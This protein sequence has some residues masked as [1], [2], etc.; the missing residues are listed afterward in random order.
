MEELEMSTQSSF[1]RNAAL[2]TTLALIVGFGAMAKVLNAREPDV[3]NARE[4]VPGAVHQAAA[5]G[6]VPGSTASASN[7]SA[8][9]PAAFS[10]SPTE[11][12][13]QLA[14]VFVDLAQKVTPAVVQ[15]E[16]RRPE[17]GSGESIQD[18]P[19]PFRQFFDL[20][21]GGRSQPMPE[22]MAGGTGF[23][24]SPEGY[25]LT[26][27]H[28]VD[29]ADR[30]VVNLVDRTSHAA[31][32]VGEDLTTDLAV[33]KVDAG[34]LPTLPMGSSHDLKVG[35]PVMAVGNP[36]FSGS[37]ALDYTVT[38]GIVSAVGRPLS[39][40]RQSLQ[41]DPDLAGYAIENFI[42]TDAVINPGNSGGPLVNLQGEVVGINS[43]IASTNGHYQGYGFAIPVD[44]AKKI[45]S[46]LMEH[47]RVRRGWLGISVTG[48]SSEDAEAYHLPRVGGVL[49]Q[50]VTSD[51]PA[52]K[53][54]LQAEDVIMAVNG[55][56]VE[57]SGDLQEAVAEL[58]PGNPAQLELYR[59]G[60]K[61]MVS[62]ELGE[63]PFSAH[64]EAKAAP[65]EEAPEAL[66]GMTV[67]DLTPQ[68]R[69][70]LGFNAAEGAVVTD[71]VPWSSAMQKGITPG[72]KINE[73]NHK[74]IHSAQDFRAAVGK[75]KPGDVVTVKF[76][77]PDG[78]SRVI[79]LRAE[80]E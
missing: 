46:D 23:V 47:G 68:L 79:N 43:A 76:E 72:M 33:I 38:T 4:S 57:D 19:E 31:K 67:S 66:L 5:V 60:H 58:G 1:S 41:Q 45:A 11:L 3:R 34:R 70:E 28:V 61:Q 10:G 25:I 65:P 49:I 56:P 51:G 29:Q 14:T 75:V 20:P 13:Q 26:N 2:V 62:V 69:S 21:Q 8:P 36:G 54:G 22:T 17:E 12:S 64:P 37:Q 6:A 40:I 63:A 9:S 18:I 52:D 50:S 78:V 44:L 77:T 71:V 39:I 27:A 7:P 59:G 15:V 48:I 16:V 35:E 55:T 74:A 73:V 53:A 30:I 24:I 32:L 42:Q 80:V